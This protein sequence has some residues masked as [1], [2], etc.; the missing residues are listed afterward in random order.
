MMIYPAPEKIYWCYSEWQPG[1]NEIKHIVKF[2]QGYNI[3]LNELKNDVNTHK[4]II[5]MI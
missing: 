1:Y 2:C 4:L 3:I 5:F